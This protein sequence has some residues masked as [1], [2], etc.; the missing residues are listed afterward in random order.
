MISECFFM[1]SP[2][3][4]SKCL[5]SSNLQWKV[6]SAFALPVRI[7]KNTGNPLKPLYHWKNLNTWNKWSNTL[8]FK[9][10]S[11]RNWQSALLIGRSLSYFLL[12]YTAKFNGIKLQPSKYFFGIFWRVAKIPPVFW[13]AKRF[14]PALFSSEPKPTKYSPSI[15]AV[16]SKT[17]NI[18]QLWSKSVN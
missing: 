11:S 10:Y 13:Q 6:A 8:F 1:Y 7:E 12:L 18:S 14:S 16:S 5:Y 9:K 2:C 4:W 17:V 15:S 3:N